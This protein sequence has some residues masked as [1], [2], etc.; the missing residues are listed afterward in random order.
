[1]ST[2]KKII[3]TDVRPIV[4]HILGSMSGLALARIR[5]AHVTPLNMLDNGDGRYTTQPYKHDIKT[6]DVIALV[7]VTG[8]SIVDEQP[9][10]KTGYNNG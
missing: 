8:F 4:F 10:L 5:E 2:I 1:M 3:V 9:L 6:T 7:E